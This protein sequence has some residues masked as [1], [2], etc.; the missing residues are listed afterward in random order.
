[1]ASAPLSPARDANESVKNFAC[2]RPAWRLAF[3]NIWL[4]L[5]ALRLCVEFQLNRYGL[6]GV[7][8]KFSLHP[9]KK[10]RF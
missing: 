2:A 10:K 6:R 1:V 5:A 4:R 7:A 8:M 3:Q 9:G